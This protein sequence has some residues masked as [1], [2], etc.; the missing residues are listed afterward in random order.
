MDSEA[1]EVGYR[2]VL[3]DYGEGLVE[4]SVTIK[5]H[6]RKHRPANPGLEEKT[7]E[8]IEENKKRA[9]RRA[10]T[11]VRQT[12]MAAQL[13]HLLTL[14]YRA[15]QTCPR[16]A[17]QHFARFMRLVRKWRRGAPYS[18]IAVLERQ[19]R[20]AIH[21]HVAVHG[22]QDVKALRSMWHQAIGSSEGNIDVSF[23]RQPLPKL[24]RYLSKYITKDIESGHDQGDHRYKRSRG[25]VVPKIVAMLPFHVAVDAKLMEL[26]DSHG[27][28]LVFHKNNLNAEG[29][30]WLWGCSW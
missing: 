2:M 24:A 22:F 21:I 9:V 7:P 3:R 5:R 4:A 1:P 10:R 27:A 16:L 26:F 19:K 18:F 8:Q 30:K 11:T 25:I 20:G 29:A 14:T 17:W 12:I 28:A 13:D 6:E 15:N 23:K